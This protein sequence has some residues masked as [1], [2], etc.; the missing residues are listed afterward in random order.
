MAFLGGFPRGA[1]EAP[2]TAC[3]PLTTSE[4]PSSS[5]EECAW[6]GPQ[7]LASLP[8]QPGNPETLTEEGR[9][10]GTPGRS[11]LSW[12]HLKHSD[13]QSTP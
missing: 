1:R 12:R 13:V 6:Q 2:R 11:H 8:H 9:G 5:T 10:M 7:S 4:R 3:L